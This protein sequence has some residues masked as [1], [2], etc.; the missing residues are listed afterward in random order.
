MAFQKAVD[1]R[2]ALGR[3]NRLFHARFD[4]LLTPTLAVPAFPVGRLSPDGYDFEDWLPWSP[5]TYPFNLTGQ[6]A[7]TVPC[8]FTEQGLPV[9]LQ[10]VGPIYGDELVLR[11]ANTYQAAHST[12]DRQPQI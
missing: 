3:D 6:P 8:G 5:F 2:V 7:I 1:Q 11:V 9:G 4:I 12:L 10:I